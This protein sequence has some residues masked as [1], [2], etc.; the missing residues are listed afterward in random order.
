[1]RT[2][3]WITEDPFAA[4]DR[5]ETSPAQRAQTLCELGRFAAAVT[6]AGQAISADPRSVRGWCLMAEAQLGQDN[7]T[8]A[9]QAARAASSL[10]PD[11]EMPHR[12]VSLA[13]E[14]LGRDEEAAQA[15]ARATD[16]APNSWRAHARLADCLSAL[17]SRLADALEA[18]ERA[19][20]LEPH[21]AGPYLTIGR[22]ALA[23]GRPTDATSAFC[24]A[25]GADPQCAEAHSQLSVLQYRGTSARRPWSRIHMRVSVPALRGRR[26]KHVRI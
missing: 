12:L 15:A 26:S 11:D 25:L 17:P 10:Q 20:D 23:D 3:P 24:A 18:A 19:R 5:S 16:C 7:G 22:V 6:A 21:E 1:M 9:L 2:T 14:A 13:L 8:A 4:E